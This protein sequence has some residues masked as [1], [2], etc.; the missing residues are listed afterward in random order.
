MYVQINAKSNLNDQSPGKTLSKNQSDIQ[1]AHSSSAPKHLEAPPWHIEIKADE[2]DES[3]GLY[4]GEGRSISRKLEVHLP[5]AD[6]AKLL[7]VLTKNGL[8]SVSV[9]DGSRARNA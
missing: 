6:I 3:G 5:P 4:G 8:L 9:V 2:Y 1:I 7:E